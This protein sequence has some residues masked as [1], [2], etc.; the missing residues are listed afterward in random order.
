[1]VYL[2]ETDSIETLKSHALIPWCDVSG[3]V[4]NTTKTE[5]IPIG[6][7]E[8]RTNLI[9]TRKLNPQALPFQPSIKIAEEGQPVRVLGA[10][11]GNGVNQATPWTPTIEKIAANLKRWEANHPTS[12]GRRLITQMI[13]GGMTQ[14]L[15]KVQGMPDTALKTLKTIICNFAWSGENKPTISMAHMSSTKNK[16]GKKVLDIYTRNEA[17][18]LTWL[19]AYLKLDETRPT[20]AF[21]ADAILGND[22]PGELRSL[23]HNPHTRVNQYLQTWHSRI[24][25]ICR[26]NEDPL[27]ILQDLKDMI[28]IGKKHRVRLEAMHPTPETRAAMPAIHHNQTREPEKLDILNDKHGKCIKDKHKI[29]TMNDITTLSKN[30]PRNISK[31]IHE[32]L[33]LWAL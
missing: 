23:A 25:N 5:I 28:K 2:H 27:N 9:A 32:T 24:N 1:M 11:I 22:V 15:A 16:G 14:Y 21:I 7:K 12:E 19:Q 33:A 13:I 3:A 6:M 4:F 17:I 20:W 18:Q 30:V 8:Y 29:R 31:T 10:W 26:N